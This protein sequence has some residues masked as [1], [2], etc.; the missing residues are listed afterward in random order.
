[1][2][3]WKAATQA[4]LRG[5]V[6]EDVSAEELIDSLHRDG[7]NVHKKALAEL[8]RRAKTFDVN[9]GFFRELLELSCR[10]AE[11]E[12]ELKSPFQ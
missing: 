4:G 10:Y 12:A 3:D 8:K 5:V 1:M 2:S 6:M 9:H 7:D 11:R